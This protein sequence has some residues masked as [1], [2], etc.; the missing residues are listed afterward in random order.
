MFKALRH[1]RWIV[2]LVVIVL[3]L[4][5]TRNI[6][7]EKWQVISELPTLRS[8]FSTAVVDG[9]IYLIGGTPFQN[10]RG[11]YGLP[12]VEVYDPKTNSWERVAN[13]PT[14]RTSTEAAVINGIIYVCGGYNGIDNRAVNLKFLDIVEA[15]DPQTDTWARKQGMSVSRVDFGVG[16][17]AGKIYG[18]GG[19]VHPLDRKPEAPGRIDLVEAYDP[20]TDTWVKRAKMPTKRD[21]FGVGVVNNRI[22]AIGGGGWPQVGA[23]GP[24]L[25]TI[26]EYDPKI[27]RWERKNEM[28]NLRLAFSTVVLDDV[29][30]LIG[31]FIWQG[32]V[33]QYL[34]TV[35]TY[36]PETEEWNDIP[37]MPTPFMPFGAAVV[38]GNIYVFGGIGENREHFTSV[39]IFGVGFPTVEANGKLPVEANGK[40]STRWGALKME[41]EGQP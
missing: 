11:P 9:K 6:A 16:A 28:P 13:M 1:L 15:Y 12:T 23:G 31:G 17:V 41:R 2:V 32:R 14:S 24:F 19:S 27:N 4:V 30:H 26:E 3:C 20:A 29:I 35:D 7:G 38:D 25:T 33:P 21:G 36:N 8:G 22:Y 37:P 5:T 40:L 34:A 10:R 39:M 18:I